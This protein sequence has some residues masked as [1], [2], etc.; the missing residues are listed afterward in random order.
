MKDPLKC[1]SIETSLYGSYSSQ[2]LFENTDKEKNLVQTQ[3]NQ[4]KENHIDVVRKVLSIQT[5]SYIDI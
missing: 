3:P 1:K 2:F 5:S 4:T